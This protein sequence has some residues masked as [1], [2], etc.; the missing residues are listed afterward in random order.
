MRKI[1]IVGHAR[2]GKDTVAEMIA[3]YLGIE[4]QGTSRQFASHVRKALSEAVCDVQY[5]SDQ[6]CWEDRVNHRA[7]W[8]VTIARFCSENKTA[9]ADLV[10][11]KGH[12]YCGVRAQAEYDAIVAKYDPVIFWVSNNSKPKEPDSSMQLSYDPKTMS[13]ITNDLALAQLQNTVQHQVG[14]YFHN[15]WARRMYEQALVAKSWSKDVDCK[16]GAVIVKPDS[17]SFALGYNGFAAGVDDLAEYDKEL[18]N[19]YTIH[20]EINA[21]ANANTDV[22]GWSMVCTKPP[23]IP[24]ASLLIQ[25][26]IASLMCPIPSKTSRW[27]DDNLIALELLRKAQINVVLI[28]EDELCL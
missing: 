3:D 20:A 24:C 14:Q 5:H 12:I 22:E 9:A 18:K 15:K 11:A 28:K 8:H 13:L 4:F 2:H 23:C 16:V 6:E 17:R 21:I 25:H 26:G 27:Y 1:L 19:K 10:Y 7:D